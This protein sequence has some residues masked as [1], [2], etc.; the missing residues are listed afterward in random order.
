MKFFKKKFVPKPG[1]VIKE[2][3]SVSR[4]RE[5]NAPIFIRSN[6]GLKEIAG[7][8]E[9]PFQVGVAIPLKETNEHGLPTPMEQKSLDSIEDQI[10]EKLAHDNEVLIA[11]ILTFPGVR[12]FS[13]Y[14]GN[15]E[16]VKSRFEELK[17]SIDSHELQ[18][19]IQEDKDWK[20]YKSFSVK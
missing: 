7:H 11:T 6:T 10:F 2:Q 15:K 14:A 12:E 17:K 4:G 16:L 19:N 8:P 18:L 13:F 1:L 9:Y 3:W 5:N 20:I